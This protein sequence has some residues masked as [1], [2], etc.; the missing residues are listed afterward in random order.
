M[1]NTLL[2]ISTLIAFSFADVHLYTCGVAV[3]GADATFDIC[4]DSD[5]AVGGIQFT[6]DGGGSGFSVTVHQWVLQ[7]MLDLPFQQVLLERC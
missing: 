7:G 1:K 2:L 4:M 5:E 3:G 6:F